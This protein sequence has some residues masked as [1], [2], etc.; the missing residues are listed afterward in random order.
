MTNQPQDSKGEDQPSG[1]TNLGLHQESSYGKSKTLA[2]VGNGI[3]TVGGE[4]TEPEGLNRDVD[5]VDKELYS[6]ERTKGNMDVTIPNDALE[7]ISDAI[8]AATREIQ[9]WGEKAS[10]EIQVFIPGIEEFIKES[11]RQGINVDGLIEALGSEEFKAATEKL[12][13]LIALVESNPELLQQALAEAKEKEIEPGQVRLNDDGT[14][15]VTI[16]GHRG[17]PVKTEILHAMGVVNEAVE[18]VL[19]SESGQM[20]QLLAAALGGV[21]RLVASVAIDEIVGD[22][23][24][25]LQKNAAVAIGAWGTGRSSVEFEEDVTDEQIHKHQNFFQTVE[26]GGNL[27]ITLAAIVI[28][29]KVPA[30]GKDSDSSSGSTSSSQTNQV[31]NRDPVHHICTDKNCVSTANGGPWTPR[32]EEIFKKADLDLNDAVNKVAVP[33]HKGPHP[34]AYHNYV[35]QELLS[36]TQGLKPNTVAY[37]SAVSGTLDRIRVEATTAGSVVNNWLTKK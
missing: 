16:N 22:E 37:K 12:Q 36:A 33:E 6:I 13:P 26:G 24:E 3:I 29:G 20:V 10:P 35:Y 7:Q 17:I 31:A 23:L 8:V 9:A 25:A 30:K 18:A 1:T 11:I 21:P 27:T 4:E 5:A 34:E 15:T 19:Q 28:G 2:T 32:F 14:E